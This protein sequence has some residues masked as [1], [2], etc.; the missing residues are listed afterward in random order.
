MPNIS[1][2]LKNTTVRVAL[3]I[4]AVIAIGSLAY[5]LIESAPPKVTYAAVT[6]GNITDDLNA[7]GIVSPL[8]NP[9]LYFETGGQ[10]RYVSAK[11][12]QQVYA[13]ALLATLD[14][15]VLSANLQ[16]AQA[17]LNGLESGPRGVDVAGQQTAVTSA[18]QNLTNAYTNYPTTLVSTFAKAQG[19]VTNNVDPLFDFSNQSDP[20]LRF[21]T[22]SSYTKITADGERQQLTLMFAT[23]QNELSLATS[24]PSTAQLQGL[25]TESLNHLS[26]EQKFLNDVIVAIN[27]APISSTFTQGQQTT[28]LTSTHTALDIVN[29]LIT[30]LQTAQQSLTSGQ[31]AVQSATDQLNVS[32]AG[33][34][35]Q[36]IQAQQA[37]VAA[38]EAQIRQQEVIAPFSGMVASV[39]V[40]SGDVVSATTPAV[41]LIPKGTF[42]VDVYVA[43]NDLPALVVGNR[44]DVTLD[45]YGT[46][47]TFPATI[48]A[49][50]TSPST[51]PDGTQGYKV[52]LIFDSADPAIA[53]G[54]HANATIHA[55][56]ASNVLVVPKSA[57]ITN[58]SST[59]VLKETS[60]GP[61]P[62]PV[63]LGLT[64][65]TQ[66]EVK[67][68]LSE[69]DKVSVVG[70]Q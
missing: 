31:I 7:D 32:L 1:E 61:V 37:A 46:G 43:E 68:G 59:Y 53:N 54:M 15:G 56:T 34:T 38:I 36:D 19:A 17:R 2:L 8:Q 26:T 5:Y 67:T 16:A 50:D 4:V 3:A 42:E 65:S 45:A 58:G 28:A 22:N 69:G 47:R 33:A 25:T 20:A 29:G 49:I 48:S 21:T 64:S 12:G 41:I 63:T 27:D 44:S 39:N 11:V 35:S 30:S 55:G 9:T 60:S 70:A 62:I 13:G 51:K 14:T 66:V 10:V 24:S 52:T 40:K 57:I 23:W 18:Q 6:K